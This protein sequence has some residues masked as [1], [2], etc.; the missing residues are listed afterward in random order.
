MSY[1]HGTLF[2]LILKFFINSL[3][4]MLFCHYQCSLLSFKRSLELIY[5]LSVKYKRRSTPNTNK[6]IFSRPTQIKQFS[7]H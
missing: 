5:Q 2:T 1:R 4:K 7:H 6:T 3:L